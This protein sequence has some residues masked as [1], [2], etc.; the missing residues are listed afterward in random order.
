MRI[1][2]GR[3]SLAARTDAGSFPVSAIVHIEDLPTRRLLGFGL[4][5]DVIFVVHQLKLV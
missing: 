2:S 4:I 1:S 5:A 3:S